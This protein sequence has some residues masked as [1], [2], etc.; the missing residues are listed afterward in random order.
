MLARANSRFSDPTLE[1]QEDHTDTIIRMFS[2]LMVDPS[3]LPFINQRCLR[4]VGRPCW[5]RTL[6]VPKVNLP[7]KTSQKTQEMSKEKKSG[8]FTRRLDI[9]KHAKKVVRNHWNLWKACRSHSSEFSLHAAVGS[10]KRLIQKNSC[11]GYEVARA[12]KL[13]T[14][15]AGTIIRKRLPVFAGND[16]AGA[17]FEDTFSQSPV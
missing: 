17:I 15:L 6:C 14:E 8:N 10:R 13:L 2:L 3:P 11:K 7:Q 5:R 1:Q 16:R 9:K 12:G 4:T